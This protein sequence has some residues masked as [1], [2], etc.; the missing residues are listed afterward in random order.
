[1][2]REIERE[3]ERGEREREREERERER[4]E[5]ERERAEREKRESVCLKYSM[6]CS[7]SR[8][9]WFPL[10]CPASLYALCVSLSGGLGL[11]LWDDYI[12]CR[13][14]V[15]AWRPKIKGVRYSVRSKCSRSRV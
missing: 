11:G 14:G 13:F 1:M 8:N 9:Q 15:V 4:T 7:L 5:R 6:L 10:S 2:L 3:R 12:A